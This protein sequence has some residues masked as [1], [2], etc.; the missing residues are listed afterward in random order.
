MSGAAEAGVQATSGGGGIS[1]VG[2]FFF[3][4][5][6]VFSLFFGGCSAPSSRRASLRNVSPVQRQGAVGGGYV[7]RAELTRGVASEE[8]EVGWEGDWVPLGGWALRYA[9]IEGRR[10]G[11]GGSGGGIWEAG[12]GEG[13]V[14]LVAA[15]RQARYGG[16]DLWLGYAPV[17][18]GGDLMVHR[19]DLQ[20]N[21]MPLVLRESGGAGGGLGTV[22]IDPGHGGGN[23][24]TRHILDGSLEK[25]YTL[26]W[27]LRLAPLLK[28]QGWRVFMTRT[29]DVDLSLTDRVRMADAVQADLFLSLHFN[30]AAPSRAQV[31]VETFCLTPAGLP[32]TLVRGGEDDA[33]VV[34]ANNRHDEENLR[35]AVKVHGA[36]V[37][38]T[39]AVDRGVRRA[40]FMTVI[41]EQDRPAVLVEGGFL[42]N[43][44]EARKIADAG[45]RQLLAEAVASAL[46]PDLPMPGNAGW[47]SRQ[48]AP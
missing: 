13:M 15:S 46:R 3:V 1:R 42:S 32:S 41:R 34:Y 19:V 35:W 39:G 27:G 31:G 8:V 48:L 22:L 36:V 7:S 29:N 18:E 6:L 10:V 44:E 20:K 12:S 4:G 45:Y 25:R 37:R 17:V 21:I 23:E 16:M 33:G 11:V 24:G 26:D 28:R 2:M 5:V 30:S 47:S 9:G 14:Q 43:P 38:V 40:R